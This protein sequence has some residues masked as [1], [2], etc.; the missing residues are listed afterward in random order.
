MDVGNRHYR[1]NLLHEPFVY[2]LLGVITPI[3]LTCEC[4]H[5]AKFR[6]GGDAGDDE[7]HEDGRQ[8]R[9]ED[10]REKLHPGV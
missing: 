10:A 8:A 1:C 4:V 2:F 5:D 7:G 9:G 3:L 6:G